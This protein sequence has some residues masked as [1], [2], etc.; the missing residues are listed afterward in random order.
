KTVAMWKWI[1]AMGAA[2]LAIVLAALVSGGPVQ[3][4]PIKGTGDDLKVTADADEAFCASGA[5]QC[6][7]EGSGHSHQAA[8]SANHNP[9]TVVA[10]VTRD[11]VAVTGLTAA[12]FFL[13]S[14]V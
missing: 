4:K 10:L 6:N 5:I 3:A 12:N 1:A 2:A 9:V 11:G 13:A 7:D 14:H 8:T